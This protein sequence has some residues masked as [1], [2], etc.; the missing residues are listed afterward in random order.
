MAVRPTIMAH[1]ITLHDHLNPNQEVPV[2]ADAISVIEVFGSG[3]MLLADGITV[4]VHETPSEVM[5]LI[6]AAQQQ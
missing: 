6:K 2:D 3:S 4:G 1:W 5:A